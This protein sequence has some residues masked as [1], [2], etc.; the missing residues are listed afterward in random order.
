MVNWKCGLILEV[1]SPAVSAGCLDWRRLF[2]FLINKPAT[3]QRCIDYNEKLHFHLL[4]V[5]DF[6][7]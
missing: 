6:S 3:Y 2:L 7:R 1:V 5:F 4:S